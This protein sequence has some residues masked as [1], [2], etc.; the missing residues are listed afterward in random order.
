MYIY[1]GQ[2][3]PTNPIPSTDLKYTV[4]GQGPGINSS[5]LKTVGETQLSMQLSHLGFIFENIWFL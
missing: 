1:I 5:Q 2:S 3:C 4:K